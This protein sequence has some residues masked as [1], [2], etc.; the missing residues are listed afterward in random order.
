M[1][2]TLVFIGTVTHQIINAPDAFCSVEYHF[3]WFSVQILGSQFD[4]VAVFLYI[5]G[6]LAAIQQ[7]RRFVDK[8]YCC[9][10]GR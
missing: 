6:E 8:F 9:F 4:A 2:V 1:G 5:N 7:A 3:Q 10:A